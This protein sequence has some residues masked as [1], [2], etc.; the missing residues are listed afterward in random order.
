MGNGWEMV[1]STE[2]SFP[3]VSPTIL[4]CNFHSPFPYFFIPRLPTSIA[5]SIDSFESDML[6]RPLHT[7]NNLK[8]LN[9]KNTS[10]RKHNS[11]CP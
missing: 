9:G 1:A 7:G 2:I 8:C 6:A 11:D 3:D 4:L 5:T 10:P